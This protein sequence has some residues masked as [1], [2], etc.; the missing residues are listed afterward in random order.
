M[1]ALM[2][3]LMRTLITALI[4]AHGQIV[5]RAEQRGTVF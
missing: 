5:L 3:A 2:T 4:A 1:N